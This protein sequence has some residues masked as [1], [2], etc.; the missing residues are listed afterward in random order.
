M[1]WRSFYPRFLWITLLKRFPLNARQRKLR[2]ILQFAYFL[3]IHLSNHNSTQ[4]VA[5]STTLS[6]AWPIQVKWATKIT[7]TTTPS[8]ARNQ[9]AVKNRFRPGLGRSTE[10]TAN[11][12]PTP[13]LCNSKMKLIRK[14]KNKRKNIWK[15]AE[16]AAITTI[17]LKMV[18]F[19]LFWLIFGSS[20]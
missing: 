1:S 13:A 2:N 8:I 16:I 19:G 20:F 3:S 6:S 7:V 5:I 4:L 15:N 11:L 10:K 14:L 12:T 17:R 18:R 9:N